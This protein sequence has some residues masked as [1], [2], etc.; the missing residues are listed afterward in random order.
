MIVS[1][2]DLCT[3][4]YFYNMEIIGCVT[5]VCTKRRQSIFCSDAE[6]I[7]KNARSGG[8]QWARFQ[9]LHL[10][11]EACINICQRGDLVLIASSS[12][13]GSDELVHLHSHARVYSDSIHSRVG[14]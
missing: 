12:N 2:P 4:T 6:W 14:T 9:A 7:H 8:I 3:I 11:K 10:V 5:I 1:I 13:D